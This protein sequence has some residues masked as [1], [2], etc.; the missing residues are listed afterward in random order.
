MP[1]SVMLCAINR[2]IKYV[3]INLNINLIYFD[4]TFGEHL[5]T[6]VE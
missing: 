1:K 2:D 3:T 4:S 6:F 5:R